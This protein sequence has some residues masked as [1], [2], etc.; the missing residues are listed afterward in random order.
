M[1][2]FLVSYLLDY[3]LVTAILKFCNV[4]FE[5]EFENTKINILKLSELEICERNKTEII[6]LQKLTKLV[7]CFV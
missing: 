6:L 3:K 7:E 5:L 2:K 4:A 1:S